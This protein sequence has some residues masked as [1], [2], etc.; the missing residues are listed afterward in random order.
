MLFG[1]PQSNILIFYHDYIRIFSKSF[2]ISSMFLFNESA[3]PNSYPTPNDGMV[4]SVNKI[5]ADFLMG[6]I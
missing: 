4:T 1:L 3:K 5:S 6:N 2:N